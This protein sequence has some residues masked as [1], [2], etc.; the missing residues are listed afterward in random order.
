MKLFLRAL[1]LFCALTGGLVS[2]VAHAAEVRVAVA[3]NFSAPMQKIAA[4]FAA[5]TGH[6]AVLSLGSTGKLFAQVRNGAPF[7]VLLAA[8]A[9]TPARLEAQGLAQAG[10]RFTYAT[11]RLVLWSKQASL[12]DTRGE[13]LRTG[14]FAHIALADPKLAPYG[15]AAIQTL[16]KLGLLQSLQSR[17][18]QGESIAQAYQFVATGN[19]ALGFVALAQVTSDGRLTEGSA[20]V[21][22]ANLHA[23]I[24]QDAVL[25]T[26][27]R[28]A[29]AALALMAYLKGD[30]ARK[31]MQ[32]FGYGL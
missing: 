28:D 1:A 3:A 8:D 10:T 7:Q 13:V 9:D 23:P 11:G 17:M 26:K 20:W 15:A 21:V 14:T 27:G 2:G 24:R 16:E 5:D 12:V 31:T 22:P 30:K 29:P 18:V 25:L 32:S 19:A 4:E 6:T